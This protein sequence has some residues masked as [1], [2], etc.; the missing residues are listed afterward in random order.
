M[1]K[2]TI[3]KRRLC[4]VISIGERSMDRPGAKSRSVGPT[5]RPGRC[6]EIVMQEWSSQGKNVKKNVR[7]A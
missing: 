6:E 5:L 3:L 2:Y 4:V 1:T 7:L